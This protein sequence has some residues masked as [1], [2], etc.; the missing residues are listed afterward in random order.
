METT[1]ALVDLL[2]PT[3]SAGPAV[4]PE[5]GHRAH[6][7]GDHVLE[8][9]GWS[10][11]EFEENYPGAPLASR[12]LVRAYE[13]G[14]AKVVRAPATAAHL[15][16]EMAGLA[17]PVNAD[18]PL[19]ACLPMPPH[20]SVPA[21]GE[22][23][24]AVQTV[25][26][27]LKCARSVYVSGPAGTGKDATPS[28]Y[29]ALT[30]TPGLHLQISPQ[31]DIQSW[32]YARGFTNGETRWEEGRLLKALRD[33]YLTP[34][35]RRVPYIIVLSDIDRAATSQMEYLRL[36]LDSIEGRI[37]GPHGEAFPVLPGTKIIATANSTGGGDVTGRYVSAKPVDSSIMN[38]FE[39]KVIYPA[40]DPRDEE[41]ILKAKFPVLSSRI[42]TAIPSMVKA[43]NT[44]RVAIMKGD[45]SC[46][47][48]HRDLCGWAGMVQ[49]LIECLPGKST[50][51]SVFLRRGAR[52]VLDGMPDPET[53][54]AVETLLD[55]HL[56]GGVLD[57][58]DTSHIRPGKLTPSF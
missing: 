31:T 50:D 13:G 56:K 25:I 18:V 1:T 23:P 58:G 34:S 22:L 47:F 54:K 4:C 3:D 16:V 38:R 32:F 40:M 6:W 41:P 10:P 28:A 35:G 48:S 12:E 33:G 5:C 39:R 46:E 44:V 8:S 53:R 27:A 24:Q 21:H 36:I 37:M 26:L 42:K 15:T 52:S 14:K 51:G 57:P 17:L 55:P 45:I 19:E 49:D 7:L 29:S 30:R 43:A 11:E 20:Y 9:H 2:H